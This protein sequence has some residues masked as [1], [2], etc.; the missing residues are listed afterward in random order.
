MHSQSS[1][2]VIITGFSLILVLLGFITLLAMYSTS[3][4]S[5]SL[6]NI[7]A[8]QEK[9]AEI[10][11]MRDIAHQRVLLLYTMASSD[12]VFER[13][14]FHIRYL[15]MA[16]TFMQS[17]D[18]FRAYD[19]DSP[20][21]NKY[22]DSWDQISSR[23]TDSARLQNKAL[24]LI[25]NDQI[26]EA[27]RVLREEV[28]PAQDRVIADFTQLLETHYTIIAHQLKTAQDTNNN[29]L[30]LT[31]VLGALILLTGILITY[32][33]TRYNTRTENEL[34]RQHHAAQEA[35]VAKSYFLAN[36]SHEIRTPLS[37]IIGFSEALLTDT[38][39]EKQRKRTTET[40]IRNGRHLQ[41]II[42]DILDISKI[43]AGQLV[44]ESIA[45]SPYLILDEIDSLVGAKAR[46]K[47]LAFIVTYHFPLPEEFQSDPTRLKQILI[48][49][50]SNAVKFTN[51]GK[52]TI[53]ASYDADYRQMK[54]L[55][56]DT[57][58]GMT[59]EEVEHIFSP[60]TQ[61]DS[62]TTRKY[63]GTGL[64]LSISN[65]LAQELKGS[66]LCNSYKGR[67]TYFTL[68][69]PVDNSEDL[70]LID[71][72][73]DINHSSTEQIPLNNI[74]QLDGNILLVED[75]PDNQKL[76]KMYIDKTGASLK[77]VENGQQAVDV[78]KNHEYDL[79]LMDMQ[80]PIM[81]G[82]EATRCLRANGYTKP[83][84]SLTANA[85]ISN[86]QKC[87]EAG[88]DGYLVKP[89]DTQLFYELLN[90]YLPV[91]T[92]TNKQT[93]IDNMSVNEL[94][95]CLKAAHSIRQWWLAFWTNFPVSSG[96]YHIL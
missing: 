52:I 34:I 74:R 91:S 55:V 33:V 61:A 45:T 70:T 15:D 60:F 6:D 36:M 22:S 26:E 72:L 83:I 25:L 50:C 21:Q 78:C 44:I 65:K 42:N 32:N 38:I 3:G 82:A 14:E 56:M 2:I 39:D 93:G 79:I 28:I 77:I 53:D 9:M 16:D 41:Q 59:P 12:D 88:A 29:Y 62:S 66:L 18:R 73:D 71:Q 35:S 92:N 84:V 81:D 40:I 80:M 48:N 10:F 8:K 4:N 17:R 90:Q 7:V 94:D 20:A 24:N 58:I 57:G 49:L 75:T 47:G 27:Q 63:G 19:E 23:V 68:I 89:V 37:S 31:V 43:E 96:R 95:A 86:R 76:I 67:G 30:M 46:E 85:M 64:G 54:F 11:T 87:I 5:R 1:R 69:L 51:Q 13:D